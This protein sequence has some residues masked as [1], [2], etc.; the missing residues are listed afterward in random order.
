MTTYKLEGANC[1]KKYLREKTV[2]SP[3]S[4]GKKA[5]GAARAGK[6]FCFALY[7]SVICPLLR[8][9]LIGA[10][11]DAVFLG[12]FSDHCQRWVPLK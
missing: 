4:G 3:K 11:D 8:E 7:Y 2:I 10:G 5:K 1:T 6:L 9:A 12:L